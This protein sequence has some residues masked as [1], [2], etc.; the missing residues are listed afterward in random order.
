MGLGVAMPT[1]ISGLLMNDIG[2]F[3]PNGALGPIRRL[4]PN[5]VSSAIGTRPPVIC[6]ICFPTFRRQTMMTGR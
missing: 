1:R 2:P 4:P 3:V 5:G 6:A